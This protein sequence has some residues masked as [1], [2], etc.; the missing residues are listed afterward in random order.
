[1]TSGCTRAGFTLIE[2]M[3]AV[4]VVGI[5][6]AIAYPAYQEQVRQTRRA[7]VTTVLLENAQ[8][9]ERHFT[10]TGTYDA[11]A[12]SLAKQSP[13]SGT[14]VYTLVAVRGPATFTLT[15]TAA[16]GGIMAQDACATYT[17]NQVG[18]RTPAD[19]QCWRR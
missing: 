12:V 11:G 9:L 13:V 8:L 14:A 18:Q 17:F 2:L 4:A 5:L 1:M 19:I 15:A 10:R 6:A 7:E 3:I 16:Q